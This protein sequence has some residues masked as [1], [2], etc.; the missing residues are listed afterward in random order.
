[1]PLNRT[2]PLATHALTTSNIARTSSEPHISGDS[3]TIS[4]LL[5]TSTPKPTFR[6]IKR[7]RSESDGD[8]NYFITELRQMFHELKVDQS[9]KIDK[10]CSAVE[11]MRSSVTFLADKYESLLSKFGK[12]TDFNLELDTGYP[13][14]LSHYNA[15]EAAV[16]N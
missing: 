13:E 12:D 5:D 1:M 11:D 6:N 16:K 15:S 8:F 4:E 9:S 3:V 2:P 10:L 14:S 7:K